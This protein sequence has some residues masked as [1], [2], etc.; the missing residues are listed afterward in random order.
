MKDKKIVMPGETL[1]T[2]EELVAGE[3]TFEEDGVIKASRLGEYV[4][5][6]KYRTAIVKPLTDI[7][8]ILKVGD[9]VFAEV[10]NVKSQMVIADVVHVI[11]KHRTIAGNITGTIHVSE[12]SRG[13]VKDATTEYKAGDVVRA[14][15][16]QVSPS[17]QL[18]T[19]G[20]KLGV[21]RAL[22]SNCRTLLQKNGK[23]LECRN[24]GNK[25]KRK[26]AVD[27]GKAYLDLKEV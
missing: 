7:P 21:I 17:L 18:S 13:Y 2:T 25:E 9:N 12:I 8:T 27:Y 6:K 1:A 22:C 26:I 16:I 5:D 4:V 15:V 11:N 10:K 19:K 14:K 23:I 24:C 20:D 3:G